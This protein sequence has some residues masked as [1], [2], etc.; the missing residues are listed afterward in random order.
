[1]PRKNKVTIRQKQKR[2][3]AILLSGKSGNSVG[4][5]MREAGYSDKYADNP[6]QMVETNSWKEIME[7]MLPDHELA[8][9]HRSLLNAHSLD[10]MVFPLGPIKAEEAEEDGNEEE[11]GS[12]KQDTGERIPLTDAQI[13]EMLAS[14][15]C[16]VRKI[17]HGQQA[18]HVYFWAPNEKARTDA[19]DMGYKLKGR[20]AA[21]KVE[22]SKTLQDMTDEELKALIVDEKK[23]IAK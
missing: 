21:Q 11:S 14:V 6:Q 9:V 7:E 13:G 17:V 19:V 2:V 23:K 15:N 20:Y 3:A 10:H 18:R 12:R 22:I 4:A 5:A 8:K 1:M 16:V